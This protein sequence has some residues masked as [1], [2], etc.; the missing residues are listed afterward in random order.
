VSL[1]KLLPYV[2]KHKLSYRWGWPKVRPINVT[3]S[4]TYK[5]PSR[6][7]TCDV[8]SRPARELTVDEYRRIFRSLGRDPF[9]VTISGGE[10][11]LRVDLPEIVDAICTESAPGIINIPTSGTMT[12]QISSVL[13]RILERTRGLQLTVNF[14][15]DELGER[16]DAIRRTPG[17]WKKT[18][19]TMRL[20]RSL[21]KDFPHL[22]IGINTVISVFNVD[23]F[24]EIYEGLQAL[25][26][27]SH[28]TE[29]AEEREE[30]RTMGS[31]ITPPPQRYA[32]VVDF[33]VG[34]IKA[35]PRAGFGAVV[36]AF[37]LEYYALARR[38][39]AER[40]QVIPCFAGVTSCHVAA[41]GDLWGCCVR[42]E[43]LGNVRD[44]DYDL[45]RL[46]QDAPARAFRRSVKAR[47]CHCPLANVAYTN[48]L[49][50]PGA[51]ARVGANFARQSAVG[52]V[53]GLDVRRRA[54]A[55]GERA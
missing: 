2:A 51:L 34:R 5:C 9:W 1:L 55:A 21:K 38:I 20:A 44:V 16:H 24:E 31:G 7:L 42:A 36:D 50:A 29:V 52:L 27:D 35:R 10:P 15:F 41:D 23:R 37:R 25:E 3:I 8:T 12:R 4:V 39:L 54:P 47:E 6:C 49:M 22:T 11:F 40:R 17:N 28:V 45:P 13:P 43:P 30:L 53:R 19:E 18:L 26:P 32:D 46:W 14:S 33:L 48:I